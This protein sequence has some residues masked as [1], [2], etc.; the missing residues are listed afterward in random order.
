MTF[1][2]AE[3]FVLKYGGVVVQFQTTDGDIHHTV[4][5]THAMAEEMF[6]NR[7]DIIYVNVIHREELVAMT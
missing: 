1:R 2:A 3:K 7:D 6:D 5:N 4:A